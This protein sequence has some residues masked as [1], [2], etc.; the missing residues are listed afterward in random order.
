MAHFLFSRAA[1]NFLGLNFQWS[2]LRLA[3]ILNV[4]QVSG[5][6]VN[7]LPRPQKP[8]DALLRPF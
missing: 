8:E 4:Y 2:F 3:Q 5:P 1:Q 7:V 6:Y